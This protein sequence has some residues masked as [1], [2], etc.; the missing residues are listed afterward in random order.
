[1]RTALAESPQDFRLI[2]RYVASVLSLPGASIE[3]QNA[4]VRE[5]RRVA[6]VAE[7]ST[8]SARTGTTAGL[9]LECLVLLRCSGTRPQRSRAAGRAIEL[10][11][12]FCDLHPSDANG[13][14]LFTISLGA[15]AIARVVE[16]LTAEGRCWAHLLLHPL[17]CGDCA[18]PAVAPRTCHLGLLRC[19]ACARRS[20][21]AVPSAGATTTAAGALIAEALPAAAE[22]SRLRLAGNAALEAPDLEESARLYEAAAA[23]AVAAPRTSEM[24]CSLPPL[25]HAVHSNLSLVRLRQGRIDD[26]LKAAQVAADAAPV[27]YWRGALRWELARDAQLIAGASASAPSRP[28][29]TPDD[30]GSHLLQALARATVAQ[31][32][33]SW[34]RVGLGALFYVSHMSLSAPC[35]SRSLPR[36]SSLP[37]IFFRVP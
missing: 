6:I 34:R 7:S 35:A 29:H 25:A 21:P 11:M 2:W 5:A 12:T 33:I 36:S 27:P 10:A 24:P 13:Y 20:Q 22:V 17:S 28:D 3:V 26:A 32:T 14:A 23:A 18:G 31:V 30:V 15:A 16:P 4:A 19:E 8:V 37:A 1:M 9:L